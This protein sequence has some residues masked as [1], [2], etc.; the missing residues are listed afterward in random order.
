MALSLSA[1]QKSIVKIFKIEEQYVVPSYQRPYSWE[2]DQCIQLYNDLLRAFDNEEDYF[3]G[4]IIIAKSDSNKGSLEV[5]DGQQRLI[6]LL[7][8]IKVLSIFQTDLKVLFDLLSQE[9]WKG[10]NNFPRIR[11]DVFE[12]N[13]NEALSQL[14]SFNQEDFENTLSDSIDKSNNIIERKVRNKFVLNALYFYK[15]VKFYDEKNNDLEEFTYFLLRN[16]YL[17]PIE[18]GG[19]TQDEAN[20][21]A[22]VIFETINNRGMNLEDADIFKAK[23]YNKA[24]K[25]KEEAIFIDLWTDFKGNCDNL[26]LRIDDVFRYY[27][28]II[29]GKE[30]ITYSEKNLREFFTRE[31]FSPF[32]L[33]NYKDIFSDLFSILEIIELVNKER[34][35]RTQI[36]PWLQ[37]LDLYTNQ[38]PKYALVNYLFVN[39]TKITNELVNFLR[40][41][42]RFV[43]YQGSTSTVKFEVYNIIKQVS[44]NQSISSYFKED[45]TGD[46]FNYL[47]RLKKGFALLAYYLNN[48][49]SVSYSFIERMITLKDIDILP[50]DWNEVEVKDVL[51]SIANYLVV[52]VSKKNLP[53]E[54]KMN[55]FLMSGITEIENFV[56]S[57]YRYR[58]FLEREDRLKSKLVAFFSGANE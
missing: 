37:I 28:H 7:L 26:G 20:E 4:N 46:Y 51:D 42:V 23:L 44:Q 45:V 39:D 40:S 9:D 5:V 57:G 54:K 1:E 47:G 43:Y 34:V 29:R 24:K 27:S 17:L 35:G 19:A 32:E 55:F 3:I 10:T 8:L 15:W 11:T 21:K 41:L 33:K 49:N 38:Y 58:D 13:D 18:L 30:G 12:S 22:L 36:A 2:Y 50:D 16:V 56:K 31:S 53:F 6:T 48:E 14:L 52:H 25:I